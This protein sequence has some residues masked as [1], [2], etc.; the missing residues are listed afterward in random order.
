MNRDENLRKANTETMEESLKGGWAEE[1]PSQ[2]TEGK[3]RYLPHMVVHPDKQTTQFRLCFDGSSNSSGKL[4]LNDVV[5]PGLNPVPDSFKIL[6]RF[7]IHQ[8][9]ICANVEKMFL[10]VKIRKEDRDYLSY[11]FR[12]NGEVKEYRMT[13]AGFEINAFPFICT[14]IPKEYVKKYM[15]ISPLTAK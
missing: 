4:S 1:S 14:S 12:K 9:A 6:T 10:M 11:I 5:L 2:R 3:I 15:E 8:I 13:V 7:R